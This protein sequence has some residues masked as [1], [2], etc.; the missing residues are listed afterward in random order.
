LTSQLAYT[1]SANRKAVRPFEQLLFTSLNGKTLARLESLS[2]AGYKR[3]IGTAWWSDSYERLWKEG[4]PEVDEN[5]AHETPASNPEPKTNSQNVVYL[6]ADS[7]EELTELKEGETYIIGG[8]CDHN[9]YKNLCLD[10]AVSTG[11]RSAR[12]PIGTYLAQLPTRKVLTVN[13]VVEILLKWTETKDWEN[14]LYE[15]MPKRKFHQGKF[16][17]NDDVD[18]EEDCGPQVIAVGEELEP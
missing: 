17:S 2:N 14:S 15:V 11:I 12:L 5:E 8:I 4:E 6:T 10:K 1:Y 3:W 18:E 16:R 9:R 7:S 13:Q